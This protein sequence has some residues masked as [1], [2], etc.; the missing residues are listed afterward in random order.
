MVERVR[1]LIAPDGYLVLTTPY[2]HRD[3]S[4]LGRIYDEPGISAL[5]DGWNIVERREVFR[6]DEVTWMTLGRS[7][8]SWRRG[9]APG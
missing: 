4:P 3:V 1:R 7:V 2:G 9:T 6:R 5:L 8:M